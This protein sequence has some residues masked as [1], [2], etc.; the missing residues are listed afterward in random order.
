MQIYASQRARATTVRAPAWF[1][2]IPGLAVLLAMI[3]G[4]PPAGIISNGWPLAQHDG[5]EVE[6]YSSLAEITAAADAVIVGRV[7][8]V[9]AGRTIGD[10]D[11]FVRY[12][13]V[14]IAVDDVLSGGLVDARASQVTLELYPGD[15]GNDQA[16]SALSVGMSREAT[17]FFLRN[18]G[19]EAAGLGWPKGAQQQ[20]TP[21]YR[22]TIGSAVVVDTG[23]RA[24][25]P[26]VSDESPFL[27]AVSGT[28]FADFVETVRSHG[29]TPG[30]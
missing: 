6:S 11:T 30:Q 26:M 8:N 14:T 12:A 19:L 9:A 13:N 18:K 1:V 17:V 4:A 15:R 29:K 21:F 10:K 25:T 2:A 5:V 28:N 24:V 27:T 22:L 23:G 7:Q 20:E 16:I 3:F